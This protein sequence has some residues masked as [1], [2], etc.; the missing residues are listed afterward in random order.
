[1]S[2]EEWEKFT[3]FMADK[4]QIDARFPASEVMTNKYLPGEIPE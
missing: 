1:M 4:G 3:G 2:P